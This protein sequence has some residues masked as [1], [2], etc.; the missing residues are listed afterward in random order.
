M[1]EQDSKPLFVAFSAHI[2]SQI[3]FD[4]RKAGFDMVIEA[5]LSIPKIEQSILPKLK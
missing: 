4:A 5:P 1:E 3:E 2:D